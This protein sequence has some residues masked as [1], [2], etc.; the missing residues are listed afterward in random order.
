MNSA[1]NFTKK[2]IERN[3]VLKYKI[4]I[5]EILGKNCKNCGKEANEIHH[6]TYDIP[7]KKINY[8]KRKKYN[9]NTLSNIKKM[10][11]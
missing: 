11:V 10:L 3:F 9:E 8:D 1:Y 4:E 6:T 7:I 2:D 5:R